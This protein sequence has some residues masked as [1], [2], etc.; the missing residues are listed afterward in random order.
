MAENKKPSD[1]YAAEVSEQDVAASEAQAKSGAGFWD[2]IKNNAWPTMVLVGGKLKEAAQWAWE[3]GKELF[4]KWFGKDK[5]NE[6]TVNQPEGGKDDPEATGTEPEDSDNPDAP[7]VDTEPTDEDV[8]KDDDLNITDEMTPTAI[9]AAERSITQAAGKAAKA[10]SGYTEPKTRAED[11][12]RRRTSQQAAAQAA[13]V[14][15]DLPSG[16]ASKDADY[17]R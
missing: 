6:P 3:K 9:Q 14:L 13:E 2:T 4:N 10:S 12:P 5:V 17:Q 11:T 15:G 7:D 1:Q 8:P 16:D